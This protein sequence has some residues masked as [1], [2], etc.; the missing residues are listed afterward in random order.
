MSTS[1]I[2]I[3]G[4]SGSIATSFRGLVKVDVIDNAGSVISPGNWQ[5]NLLLDSGLDKMASIPIC[6]IFRACAKGTGTSENKEYAPDTFELNATTGVLSIT[7]GTRTFSFSDIGKLFRT[8]SNIEC[9]IVSITDATH[10]VVRGV[11]GNPLVAYSGQAGNFYSVGQIALDQEVSRTINYSTV[12]GDNTTL[13]GTG[14]TAGTRTLTRTFVFPVEDSPAVRDGVYSWSGTGLT[15]DRDVFSPADVG[16]E[17]YLNGTRGTI[18]TVVT[19]REVTV[20]CEAPEPT[21]INT[22][23]G[24]VD[25][26]TGKTYT[27]IGFSD[28]TNFPA[29]RTLTLTAW[30]DGSGISTI[31]VDPSTPVYSD[32]IGNYI[33]L[34]EGGFTLTALV[35]SVSG[36]TAA[37]N[38]SKPTEF[39]VLP[40]ATIYGDAPVNVR[41]KLATPVKVGCP[42]PSTPSQQ[43]KVS[44]Q[45][46]I[47]VGP[48]VK[49]P[50]ASPGPISDWATDGFVV[51]EEFGTSKINSDGTT[52][53]DA[54]GLD[55]SNPGYLA[56]S[57]ESAALNS[58]SAGIT[59]P[60][61]QSGV[62]YVAMQASPYVPGRF[63][64]TYTG[65]FGVSDAVSTNLRSLMLYNPTTGCGF[66]TYLFSTAKTKDSNHSL[67]VTLKKN[68]NRDLS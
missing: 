64:N 61:R 45:F 40:S 55:P 15:C 63:S 22:D 11:A 44:Y 50:V 39:S 33:V 56:L 31:T 7:L 34:N 12:P 41:V 5:P 19:A 66:F 8:L 52:S 51:I 6:D 37:I 29:N 24:S 9:I 17:I 1:P 35:S 28:M 10:A 60:S 20:S 68:W 46:K 3:S 36:A 18:L 67:V 42:T 4:G 32:D 49:D 14:S 26:Y 62:S 48:I 57:N 21:V 53:T 65:Q 13:T 30:V 38:R 23:T 59:V 2:L 16:S 54:S 47:S 58:M 43:L 25:I 27:E